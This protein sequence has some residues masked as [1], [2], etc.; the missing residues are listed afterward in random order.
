MNVLDFVLKI[1]NVLPDEICD[2]L[3][4]VFEKVQN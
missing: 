2:E 4:K 3:I 1:D